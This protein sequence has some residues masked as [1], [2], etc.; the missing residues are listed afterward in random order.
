MALKLVIKNSFSYYISKGDRA[1]PVSCDIPLDVE[2]LT[3][4]LCLKNMSSGYIGYKFSLQ[5]VSFHKKMYQPTKVVASIKIESTSSVWAPIS[6]TEMDKI[7]K[8]RKVVLFDN[9]DVPASA[10]IDDIPDANKVGLDYYVQ[11]VQTCYMKD[12]MVVTL[13]IYSPDKKLTLEKNSRTFVSKQMSDILSSVMPAKPYKST[14][15][16]SYSTDKMKVLSYMGKDS[17]NN[18]VIREHI[19]PYLVQYNE[20]FY[21]MLARTCNRWGE[22]LFYENEQLNVGYSFNDTSSSDTESSEATVI[23]ASSENFKNYT[24]IDLSKHTFGDNYHRSANYDDNIIDSPYKKSPNKVEGI[25]FSPG[26]KWDTMLVNKFTSFL[27]N[28]KNLPTWLGNELFDDMFAMA[29][30]SATVSRNNIDFDD[31][32]FSSDAKKKM[33]TQYGQY[34]FKVGKDKKEK[35]EGFNPFSEISS[36]FVDTLYKTIL[37]REQKAGEGAVSIDFDTTFPGLKLGQVIA[38]N[39]EYFIV[40]QID[41]KPVYN[42]GVKPKYI[43][44]VIATPQSDTKVDICIKEKD[45]INPL[46]TTL[47]EKEV[48]I[49]YPTM[50]PT[51]H[52]R[53]A[54]PQSAKVTHTKDPLNKGRVRVLFTWQDKNEES[55]PWLQYAANASGQS[56]ISGK[57]YADDN[58]FVGYLDGNVER[59]YVI[60]A[61]SKGAGSDIQCVTPGGHVLKIN[62]DPS[63]FSKFFTGMFLPGWKTASAFF[64]QMSQFPEGDNAL[65]MGGG[66]ELSDNYGFYKISGSSDAR[67][68]TVD[69]PWGNVNINAFTGITISAPNGDVKISGKNVTIEAGNNLNLISGKNVDKENWFINMKKDSKAGMAGQFAQDIAVAVTKKLAQKFTNIVDLSIIRAITEIIFKPV[70]GSLTVKSNRFLKLEAG[71]DKCKYP[72]IAYNLEKKQALLDAENKSTIL[73]AVGSSTNFLG[74]LSNISLDNGMV[75]LITA[76]RPAAEALVSDFINQ[77]KVCV[78][79]KRL[80]VSAI[81]SLALLSNDDGPVCKT[82]AEL[83]ADFWAD[84]EYQE[85]T[86]DKLDFKDNVGILKGNDLDDETKL[87]Q[88]VSNDKAKVALGAL[89]VAVDPNAGMM[90]SQ[91]KSAAKKVIKDRSD[92][93]ARVLGEAKKLRKSICDLLKITG[94]EKE[95]KDMHQYFSSIYLQNMPKDFKDVL[96]KA[97]SKESCK[98]SPFYTISDAWKNLD[99]SQN[100]D[101]DSLLK[102]HTRRLV[103]YKLLTNLGF[104]EDT[105]IYVSGS[106]VPEPACGDFDPNGATSLVNDVYWGNYVESLSGVP[107]LQKD[108]KTLG[109]ALRAAATSSLEDFKKNFYGLK[110]TIAEISSW[111]EGKNGQILM[112]NGGKTYYMN[113]QN[114]TVVQG[115]SPTITHLSE[116]TPGLDDHQTGKLRSF[117]TAMKDALKKD[118]F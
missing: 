99:N 8:D 21:D 36:R 31:S 13:K 57:H 10:T 73:S 101:L 52:V 39:S 62:D 44:Q 54:D 68:I 25:L 64:P 92:L 38:V 40:V 70:E 106:Q 20:S 51:G 108:E 63:G 48:K 58:V 104:K 85:W 93:R 79:N 6:K 102:K 88:V 77:Y 26:E 45:K 5:D 30:K 42:N 67:N 91:F 28:D 37:S 109:G 11:E 47:K 118:Q 89:G 3:A 69:S 90:P 107:P 100:L 15:K 116:D 16:V 61:I 113:D 96:L 17:S 74:K 112:A 72:A 82:F 53:F 19:F 105:R 33:P 32:Y 98:D 29:S 94:I 75:T 43:Y 23:N 24:Y 78:L 117:V 18:N 12:S 84:G 65:K 35:K 66:F 34:E 7:F 41:C 71:K 2:S 110:N 50:L 22:F 27:R 4:T 49:F 56:G 60:G 86:E 111:G 83:K 115:V 14:E 55:S 46:K 9:T 95:R 76:V 97:M 1:R 81:N 80:F 87:H 103:A 59:P 114:F